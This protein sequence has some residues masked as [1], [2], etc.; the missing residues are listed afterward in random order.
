MINVYI[1]RNA[2]AVCKD[3][4]SNTEVGEYTK[5]GYRTL[6]QNILFVMQAQCYNPLVI[7][8]TQVEMGK[9]QMELGESRC[10]QPSSS[11]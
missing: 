5:S 4:S 8:N 1:F 10:I 2:D 3:L 7:N 9:S 6:F 11:S